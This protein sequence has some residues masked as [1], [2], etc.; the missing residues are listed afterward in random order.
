MKKWDKCQKATPRPLSATAKS[1]RQPCSEMEICLFKSLMTIAQ[2]ETDLKG[3]SPT[4]VQ[5]AQQ[6]DTVR[7]RSFGG[8]AQSLASVF[9]REMGAAFQLTHLMF[10]PTTAIL[11]L[12]RGLQ[13]WSALRKKVFRL[14]CSCLWPQELSTYWITWRFVLGGILSLT[15]E[16]L[17]KTSIHWARMPQPSSNIC[18]MFSTEG[19]VAAFWLKFLEA[20]KIIQSHW[21]RTFQGKRVYQD[22]KQEASIGETEV[23]IYSTKNSICTVTKL[24]S[25]HS[26]LRVKN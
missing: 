17:N 22:P 23:N 11:P 13:S 26:I 5:E 12:R 3:P 16:T 15:G 24:S 4:Q 19:R 8:G 1:S 10:K 18:M 21:L 9:K 6:W 7:E 2:W 14:P 20:T 25:W